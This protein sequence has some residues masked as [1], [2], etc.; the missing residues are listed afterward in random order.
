MTTNNQTQA[1]L[2][3]S[4]TTVSVTLRADGKNW[5]DWIKQ[6]TNYAAAEGA[7]RVLDSVACPTFD[8]SNTKYDQIALL[9][10]VLSADMTQQQICAAWSTAE[11]T[12][13][14]LCPYNKDLQRCKEDNQRAHKQWVSR[15]A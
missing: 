4:K 2:S 5:K 8:N 7:F 6:L 14:L 10:P 12:N 11:D 13:K 9:S 15:D 3:T 1:G